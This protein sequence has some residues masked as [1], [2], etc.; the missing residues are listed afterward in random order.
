LAFLPVKGTYKL[1]CLRELLQVIRLFKPGVVVHTLIQLL[2][3]KMQ[4]GELK[5]SPSKVREI[6]Y[7]Q[8]NKPQM[9]WGIAQVVEH[10]P[11]MLEALNSIPVLE[12]GKK[13]RLGEKETQASYGHVV[14]LS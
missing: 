13:K 7:Q 10:L 11:S 8:N 3:K 2:G 14:M 12:G 9:D 5:I 1:Y 6:L 4:D